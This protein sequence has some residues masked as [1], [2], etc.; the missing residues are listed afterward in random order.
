MASSVDPRM[1]AP[2]A[3]HGRAMA[4][5]G[6]ELLETRPGLSPLP[7]TV[8][9]GIGR[10]VA[11]GV[12]DMCEDSGEVADGNK[13]DDMPVDARLPVGFTESVAMKTCEWVKYSK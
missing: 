5:A 1:M 10:I 11:V 8:V 2:T 9:D 6:G 3:P 13:M 4:M 12:G 7:E